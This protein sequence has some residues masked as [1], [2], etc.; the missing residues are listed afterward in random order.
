M[1]WLPSTSTRCHRSRASL[2][3]RHVNGKDEGPMSPTQWHSPLNR[4]ISRTLVTFGQVAWIVNSWPVLKLE[5]VV[6]TKP[7]L[8]TSS[9]QSIFRNETVEAANFRCRL[10]IGAILTS[11]VTSF[12]AIQRNWASWLATLA[13]AKL[14]FEITGTISVEVS[15]AS[16][17]VW[18]MR[19]AT[20]V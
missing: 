14:S 17:A 11:S 15:V 7:V 8:S 5:V 10:T 13:I 16:I 4:R 2:M 19:V 18:S 20:W 12:R 9:D 3:L 6:T 1:L